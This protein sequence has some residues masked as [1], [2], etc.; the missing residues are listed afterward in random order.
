MKRMENYYNILGVS[1]NA[2]EQ[3]I[4]DR[5]RQ[6]ARQRHPDRFQGAEK[7]KAEVE[8]QAITQAHNVLTSPDRRRQHDLELA[9][10]DTQRQGV[11]RQ[12]L[13]RVHLQRGVK[14]FRDGNHLEAA[15]NFDRATKAEPENALAWY[16]LA[17]ACEQQARWRSRA[18]SAIEEACRL[19]PMKPQ[20]L[21]V[22]GRLFAAGG[23]TA[24]AL[25]YYEQARNWG[26]DDLEI[27][28]EIKRL[29]EG[30]RARAGRFGKSE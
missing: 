14:A 28:A 30:R 8:F 16:N 27:E 21:R 10:P 20:Y 12:Q 13:A 7:E 19:E 26:G 5:F 24:R 18:M 9:R 17:L 4:R 15:D 6:L 22:A 25:A 2:T 1:R 23:V 29:Q 3:Q 11:D